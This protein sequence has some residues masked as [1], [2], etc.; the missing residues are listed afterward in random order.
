MRNTSC[1]VVSWLPNAARSLPSVTSEVA[2]L[3]KHAASALIREIKI[4]S[5]SG[6]RRTAR[7]VIKPT[8]MA[9]RRRRAKKKSKLTQQTP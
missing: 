1:E 8:S 3:S 9:K 5:K 4:G 2:R 7:D 6:F